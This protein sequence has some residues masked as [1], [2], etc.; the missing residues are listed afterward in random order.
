MLGAATSTTPII[1]GENITKSGSC[2]PLLSMPLRYGSPN[3][4]DVVKLQTFLN[5]QGFTLPATG[6][7][8]PLT[9]SATKSFQRKYASEILTPVGLSSPTGLVYSSTIRK[10]NTIACGG[11]APTT[12]AA[13]LISTA[14]PS[15]KVPIAPAKSKTPAKPK[16]KTIEATTKVDNSA[17]LNRLGGWL[18]KFK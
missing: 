6:F 13:A 1:S 4:A 7:F 14:A 2:S 12:A 8:G 3:K 16:S 10:I 15:A 18:S 9:V 17:L 11:V 5:A